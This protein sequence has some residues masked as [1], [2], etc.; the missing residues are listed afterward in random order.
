MERP[1]RDEVERA[2]EATLLG[3]L[4]GVVLAALR[5]RRR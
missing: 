4:L 2:V 5:P 3:L 1:S